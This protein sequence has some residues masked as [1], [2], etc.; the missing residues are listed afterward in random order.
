MMLKE[1]ALWSE[2]RSRNPSVQKMTPRIRPQMA[3]DTPVYLP[4]T[5]ATQATSPSFVRI[6]I[7][8]LYFSGT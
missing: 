8:L 6:T 7:E 4:I 1:F 2:S 3:P 5:E